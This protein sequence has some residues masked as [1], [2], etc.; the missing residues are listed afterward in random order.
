MGD[1][2]PFFKGSVNFNEHVNKYKRSCKAS[3]P[4]CGANKF[5]TAHRP[6]DFQDCESNQKPAKSQTSNPNPN[7]DYINYGN[8]EGIMHG[9]KL[10]V[11]TLNCTEDHDCHIIIDFGDSDS[12]EWT[13]CKA[14][15]IEIV[16][17]TEPKIIIN[18]DG[19]HVNDVITI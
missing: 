2:E 18:Q 19:T 6:D 4:L 11:T 5:L 16:V 17:A 10:G 13:V 8:A 15:L 14:N 3:R 7:N 12:S 9:D 1:E